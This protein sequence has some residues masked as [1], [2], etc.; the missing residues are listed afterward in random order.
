MSACSARA[1]GL[2]HCS[3]A[4]RSRLSNMGLESNR[5]KVRSIG[6]LGAKV[7]PSV[8]D[9]IRA[10]DVVIINVLDYAASDALLK[11]V[12]IASALAGKAVVQLTSGSPRLA[13]EE[14]RLGGSAWCRLSGRSDHGQSGL[15]RQIRDR[16]A[17][18]GFP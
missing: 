13:R 16:T 9:R 12:G 2:V 7:A 3:N 8:E 10:A 17:L 14:A 15:Y 11:R 1:N 18:F 6:G 4:A 5:G